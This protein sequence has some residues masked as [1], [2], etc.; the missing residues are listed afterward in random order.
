MDNSETSEQQPSAW[1]VAEAIIANIREIQRRAESDSLFFV[2]TIAGFLVVRGSGASSLSVVG[3][4]IT[5]LKLIQF[6]FVPIATFLALRYAK[7][8]ILTN[9]LATEL[10]SLLEDH[11]PRITE[12]VSPPD[13]DITRDI[14]VRVRSFHRFFPLGTSVAM[15]G[16]ISAGV[17]INI[18][19]T[20]AHN[21]SWEILSGLATALLV[22]LAVVTKPVWSTAVVARNPQNSPRA[23]KM[24]S[25]LR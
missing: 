14:A 5:D 7:A 21:V 25:D 24:A 12:S 9:S 17:V 1:Q 2:A 8:E 3:L 22:V 23:S 10:R 15:S 19:D 4:Q 11:S 6:S 13:W 18:I 20:T 16:F